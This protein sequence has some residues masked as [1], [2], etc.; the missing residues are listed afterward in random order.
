[1]CFPLLIFSV[2]LLSFLKSSLLIYEF[3]FL[4]FLILYFLSHLPLQISSRGLFLRILLM[5]RYKLHY[6]ML[7][8]PPSFLSSILLSTTHLPC[9]M[10]LSTVHLLFINHLS[11]SIHLLPTD[12][13]P[14]PTFTTRALFN[15][16]FMALSII[17]HSTSS[18]S[19]LAERE[20]FLIF[21][22]S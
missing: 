17:C 10:L 22:L 1:M 21:F 11:S 5:T 12:H 13:P 9:P 4:V 19:I 7:L 8:H 14:P 20:F 3:S 18:K 15:L 2:S 16:L 6:T